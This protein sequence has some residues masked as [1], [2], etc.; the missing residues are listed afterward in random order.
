MNQ[1]RPRQAN[2][3]REPVFPVGQDGFGIT[4]GSQA[5]RVCRYADAAVVG[6]RLV[7]RNRRTSANKSFQRA[8]VV[9]AAVVCTRQFTMRNT[10]L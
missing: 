3:S 5:R 2:S 10:T 8:D 9:K 1:R 7:R 4:T 6:S